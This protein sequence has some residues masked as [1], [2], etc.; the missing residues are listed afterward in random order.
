MER[1]YNRI[2][3][4]F[5][6]LDESVE[7]FVIVSEENNFA[8]MQILKL[9]RAC[10]ASKL[11]LNWMHFP[12]NLNESLFIIRI[13]NIPSVHVLENGNIRLC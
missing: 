10:F 9:L 7:Y 2:I 6:E 12:E 13:F 1:H 8:K 11:F 3:T 4:E 5:K